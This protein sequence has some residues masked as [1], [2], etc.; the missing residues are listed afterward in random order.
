LYKKLSYRKQ[1]A[2][3]LR[4]QYV[5]SIYAYSNSRSFKGVPSESLA[6]ISIVT[7]TLS[8]IVCKIK[9]PSNLLVE[10]REFFIRHLY[11]IC[12]LYIA[13]CNVLAKKQKLKHYYKLHKIVSGLK[14]ATKVY[15]TTNL[16]SVLLYAMSTKFTAG[17]VVF[18]GK[19]PSV[20]SLVAA[21]MR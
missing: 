21:A 5:K 20:T 17:G 14:C 6:A 11:F 19:E 9:A 4:T 3:Q 10:N 15:K 1:I 12:H 7:I 16:F 18:H 8:E 2:R 13:T